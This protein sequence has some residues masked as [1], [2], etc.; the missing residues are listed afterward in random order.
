[1][2]LTMCV[3]VVCVLWFLSA[4]AHA[5][6]PPSRV[7]IGVTVTSNMYNNVIEDSDSHRKAY[8]K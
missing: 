5:L 6:T 3:V 2:L 7:L 1:M 8:Y 4:S